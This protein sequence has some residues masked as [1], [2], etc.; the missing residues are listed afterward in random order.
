[1]PRG[2]RLRVH[3]I[4][5]RDLP[6]ALFLFGFL[7]ATWSRSGRGHSIR[8]LDAPSEF[9]ELLFRENVRKAPDQQ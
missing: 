9:N 4:V 3:R 8:N 2:P 6:F 7:P 5:I 1:M